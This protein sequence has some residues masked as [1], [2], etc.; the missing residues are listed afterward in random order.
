MTAIK[1][2]NWFLPFRLVQYIILSAIVGIWMGYPGFMHFQFVLYS[3]ATLGFSILLA[4]DKRHKLQDLTLFLIVCQ[5]L[6]EIAIESSIIYAT[7]N[8][9]SQFSVLLILTIISASLVFRLIGTLLVASTVSAAYALI[10]WFGFGGVAFPNLSMK[11]MQTIFSAGDSIFYPIFMHILIFYLVAFIS[12][13]LA[14][15]LRK[16]DLELADTSLALQKAKLET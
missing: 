6:L 5:F 11:A 7:G 8:V 15:R 13:Y 3:I 2:Q 9:N 16:R 4:T 12:G 14:E 10:I 1:I